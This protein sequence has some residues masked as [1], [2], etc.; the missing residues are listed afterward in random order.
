V[1]DSRKKFFV[2]HSPPNEQPR[3]VELA[4][5]MRIS[6]GTVHLDPRPHEPIVTSIP[7]FSKVLLRIR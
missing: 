6:K 2:L 3:A 4:R 5:Q 7:I 1:G